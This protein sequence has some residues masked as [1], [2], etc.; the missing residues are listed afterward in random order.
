MVC[1][2]WYNETPIELHCISKSLFFYNYQR[3]RNSKL[4]F[5]A[6]IMTKACS[7]QLTFLDR[8]HARSRGTAE[9]SCK[10][11]TVGEYPKKSVYNTQ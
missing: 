9:S 1:G 6:N 3:C 2:M 4:L 8:I 10:L 5:S 11:T 7:P